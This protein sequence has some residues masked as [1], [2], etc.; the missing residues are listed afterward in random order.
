MNCSELKNRLD[1]YIDG[2][3][4]PA[5][6]AAIG[7]HARRCPPCAGLLQ[8]ERELRARLR[9]LPVPETDMGIF[10]RAIA[11]AARE[12]EERGHKR[13][14]QRWSLAGAALAATVVM[15]LGLGLQGTLTGS[16][17]PS[18]E[19]LA[20]GKAAQ[21]PAIEEMA[22]GI[23]APQPALALA[24]RTGPDIVLALNEERELSLAL[25]S[26]QRIDEATF[27][28]VLPEGVELSGYPG[29]R[30]ITWI[31]SLESGKNLLVLPLRAQAGSGG[32]LAAHIMHTERRRSLIL[33]A[34]VISPPAMP[35][36]PAEAVTVM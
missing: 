28:V 8:G 6:H 27:T 7:Q 25:E 31:G 23:P 17:A 10:S 5:E 34:E 14:R 12:E 9:G 15:A 2:Y 1:D 18:G 22:T 20:D 30:E 33:R 36:L 11:N 21:P 32:E 13:Q 26:Q 19:L 24:P 16:G 35:A 3:C 29:Q 4:T